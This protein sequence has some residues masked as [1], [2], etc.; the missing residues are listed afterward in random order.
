LLR[1][2]RRSKKEFT[3]YL[4]TARGSVVELRLLLEI[5]NATQSLG[6]KEFEECETNAERIFAMI[7]G[8]LR[9]QEAVRR[10]R[11]S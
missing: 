5:A 4:L 8:L 7:N 9:H 10:N 1:A 11:Q 3:R 6:A 2:A